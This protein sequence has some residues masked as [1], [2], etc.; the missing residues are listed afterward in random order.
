MKY[1][2]I[3]A[4]LFVCAPTAS[5]AEVKYEQFVKIHNALDMDVHMSV[6]RLGNSKAHAADNG[7]NETIK[8]GKS[9][10]FKF[11]KIKE[12]FGK[13][14][15]KKC[16]AKTWTKTFQVQMRRAGDTDYVT[17]NGTTN[18]CEFTMFYTSNKKWTKMDS[19]TLSGSNNTCDTIEFSG[20]DGKTINLKLTS[21]RL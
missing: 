21:K 6:A 1:F 5:F 18:F 14:C 10:T 4:A 19:R 13:A 15:K 17:K 8:K 12:K 11:K 2:A 16:E 9:H 3:I 7:K 20:T